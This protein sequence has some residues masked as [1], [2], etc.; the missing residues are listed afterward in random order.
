MTQ[1][2]RD[3]YTS[4]LK[5]Y[6]TNSSKKAFLTRSK[7]QCEE[8]LNDINICLKNDRPMLY[9]EPKHDGHAMEMED[10]VLFIN[11]LYS[12]I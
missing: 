12:K 10:E 8:H 6:K 4:E 1:K 11:R 7:K 3:Y 2:D 9:G 5:N